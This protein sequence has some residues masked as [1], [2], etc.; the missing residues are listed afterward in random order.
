MEDDTR[1]PTPLL[2]SFAAKAHQIDVT[3]TDLSGCIPFIH[4]L[5]IL[6][7]LFSNYSITRAYQFVKL[8]LLFTEKFFSASQKHTL[9]VRQNRE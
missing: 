1:S 3:N 4:G 2:I 6:L 5:H 7:L 8:I 9:P